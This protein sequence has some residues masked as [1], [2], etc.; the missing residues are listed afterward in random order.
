MN[1]RKMRKSDVEGIATTSAM[2][3]WSDNSAIDI[4]HASAQPHASG[5]LYVRTSDPRAART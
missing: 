2:V 5:A 3:D 1:R 4:G